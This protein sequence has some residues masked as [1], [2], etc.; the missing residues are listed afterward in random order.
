LKNGIFKK[1]NLDSFFGYG[2]KDLGNHELIEWKNQTMCIAP[3]ININIKH[4]KFFEGF[5][6]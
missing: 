5:A 2:I 3:Y 6:K 4:K 1:E